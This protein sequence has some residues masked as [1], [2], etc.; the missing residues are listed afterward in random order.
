[1][2]VGALADASG[3]GDKDLH[4]AWPNIAMLPGLFRKGRICYN[5]L[6]NSL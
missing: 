6:C 5:V 3:V 2:L 1:M 4:A